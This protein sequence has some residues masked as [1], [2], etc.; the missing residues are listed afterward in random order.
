[1]GVWPSGSA[2]AVTADAHVP[3]S[4]SPVL[5]GTP[6]D[7]SALRCE[8][9]VPSSGPGVGVP[10]ASNIWYPPGEVE[11]ARMTGPSAGPSRDDRD[12]LGRGRKG[13]AVGRGSKAG[14]LG[15]PLVV[16]GIERPGA[17][18]LRA[19]ERQRRRRK[20]EGRRAGDL[21]PSGRGGGRDRSHDGS[22]NQCAERDSTPC[23]AVAPR[24][25]GSRRSGHSCIPSRV[26]LPSGRGD[27]TPPILGAQ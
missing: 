14:R 26:P 20:A 27:D 15:R 7:P 22:H 18:H 24:M 9:S 12:A 10:P 17:E 13:R 11:P 4:A 21:P 8:K 5:T 1:M 19:G 25:R 3:H 2:I 16:A 23:S 6:Q